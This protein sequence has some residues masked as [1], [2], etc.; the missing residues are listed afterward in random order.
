MESGFLK[1]KKTYITGILAILGTLGAY[2]TG[3]ATFMEAINLIV[4]A[5]L[6]MTVRKGVADK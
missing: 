3:E 6:A 1:G 5:V 4:P 2:A